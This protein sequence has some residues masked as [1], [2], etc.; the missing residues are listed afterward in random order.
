VLPRLGPESQEASWVL[1][2]WTVIYVWQSSLR[3]ITTAEVR[4]V[5]LYS[6]FISDSNKNSKYAL[7]N[8][9]DIYWNC[10][11]TVVA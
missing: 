3:N 8:T 4:F 2:L 10:N 6:L 11:E 9:H 5:P 1:S 7:C